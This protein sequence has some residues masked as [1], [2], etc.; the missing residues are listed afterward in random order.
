MDNRYGLMFTYGPL[1]LADRP[2][3]T[4]ALPDSGHRLPQFSRLVCS[5][6]RRCI[7]TT[8][9]NGQR[10]WHKGGCYR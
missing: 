9:V 10:T 8:Q 4:P 3:L 7:P 5:F 2:Q 1:L 6:V